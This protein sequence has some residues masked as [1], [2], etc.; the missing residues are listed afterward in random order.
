M[1]EDGVH[2]RRGVRRADEKQLKY[3]VVFLKNAPRNDNG[4]RRVII[5]NCYAMMA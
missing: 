2:P 1:T 4:W 5:A 3:N